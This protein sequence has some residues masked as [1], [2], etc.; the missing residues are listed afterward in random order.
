MRE[1]FPRLFPQRWRSILPEWLLNTGMWEEE[2]GGTVCGCAQDFTSWAV[3]ALC[4]LPS[5]GVQL[6][7]IAAASSAMEGHLSS[8]FSKT[9]SDSR[10]YLLLPPC[11]RKNTGT[12]GEICL[13]SLDWYKCLLVSGFVFADSGEGGVICLASDCKESLQWVMKMWPPAQNSLPIIVVG[14]KSTLSLGC[15]ARQKK[16]RKQLFPK[17]YYC[18]FFTY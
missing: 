1:C 7:L 11:M 12:L 5:A 9:Y 17:S 14:P 16:K 2:C 15:S 18:S 10:F 3:L 4:L 6:L 13:I 8:F